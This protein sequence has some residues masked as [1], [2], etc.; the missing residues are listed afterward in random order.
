MTVLWNKWTIIFFLWVFTFLWRYIYIYSEK[1]KNR[2]RGWLWLRAS[3]RQIIISKPKKPNTRIVIIIFFFRFDHF[4]VCRKTFKMYLSTP[5]LSLR[6]SYI[7]LF[8]FFLSIRFHKCSCC[9]YKLL[10]QDGPIACLFF[11][12]LCSKNNPID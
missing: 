3:S 4:S 5:A 7:L 8:L 12:H 10:L 6:A 9:E 11:E 1:I 2:W